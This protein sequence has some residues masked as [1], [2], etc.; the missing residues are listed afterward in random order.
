MSSMRYDAPLVAGKLVY[1]TTD[2]GILGS[3]IRAATVDAGNGA[4]ILWNDWD[5][6]ADDSLKF[7]ARVISKPAALYVEEDG[8]MFWATPP[9]G[10]YTVQYEGL[11]SNVPYGTATASVTVGPQPVNAQSSVT[12]GAFTTSAS[13]TA[14]AT[15]SSSASLGAFSS[16]AAAVVSVIAN[17]SRS[18]GAFQTSGTVTADGGRIANSSLTL[19]AF[20]SAAAAN[21]AARAQSSKALDAFTT[22]GAL[23][24]GAVAQSQ[25]T[26]GAFL[27]QAT[28]IVEPLEGV[29]AVS[30]VVLGEFTQV[31]RAGTGSFKPS[32]HRTFLVM[33]DG[34]LISTW[35]ND[36]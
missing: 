12:L 13:A 2:V 18:L 16:V 30:S 34:G 3:V 20:L 11:V 14:R 6:A 25:V 32:K 8:S 10:N 26:L 19:G 28:V 5:S 17:S 22:S 24:K 29:V 15:A 9:D 33:P 31:M 23:E 7:R 4:G 1:G 21:A 35:S 36:Q 27:T